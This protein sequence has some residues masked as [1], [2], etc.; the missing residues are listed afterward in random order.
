MRTKPLRPTLLACLLLAGAASAWAGE[1]AADLQFN[2]A[3]GLYRDGL[4]KLA[5]TE[6]EKFVSAHPKDPR[7][8]RARFFLGEC[9][10]QGDD[11]KG[12]VAHYEAAVKDAALPDRP[13]ALYRL[14]DCRF[15]LGD[16]KG[17]VAPLREFIGSQLASQDHKRHIVHA[18]YALARAEMAERR[19]DLALLLFQGVL[20]DTSKDNTYKPYVLLPI[21]DCLAALKRPTEALAHYAQLEKHLDALIGQTPDG[22][23]LKTQRSVLQQIRMKMA[24][25][26]L[27]G[28]K[29]AEALALFAKL[30]DEGEFAE[31]ALYGRTQALFFLQR[32][33][34]AL[35]P[36][37]AYLKR[38]PKG[39][40]RAGALYIAAE[41]HYRTDKFAE[42]ERLFAEFLAADKDGKHPA[43]ETAAFGRVAAAYRQGKDH[44]K[45]TAAAA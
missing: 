19:Y 31:E 21:G 30:P 25:V 9:L 34:D 37:M 11:L 14:G 1:S 24:N 12:A 28:R 44:A 40:L 16:V 13:E 3:Q 35:A 36:A 2:Y 42:A 26:H 29:Y 33:P 6:L 7:G 38:F 10:R 15:R 23:Q 41:A 4:R 45:A 27:A 39:R 8:G 43:R 18:T 20:A 17:S 5:I 32:Y 22:P